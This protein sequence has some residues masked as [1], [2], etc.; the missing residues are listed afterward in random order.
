M[1]EKFLAECAYDRLFESAIHL[2]ALVSSA[3]YGIATYAPAM[4][5][6]S[7]HITDG[8]QAYGVKVAREG[9][10]KVYVAGTCGTL[11]STE[12]HPVFAIAIGA[13]G[14]VYKRCGHV[15]VAVYHKQSLGVDGFAS[16]VGHVWAY[17]LYVGVYLLYVFYLKGGAGITLD[18]AD[19]FAEREVATKILLE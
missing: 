17:G 1:T 14:T 2:D 15:A 7:G 16:L 11:Y 18:A 5:I 4:V 3:G 19:A 13:F 8:A 10:E 12:S 9:L 6:E